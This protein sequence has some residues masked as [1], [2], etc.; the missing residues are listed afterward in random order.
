MSKFTKRNEKQVYIM[1]LHESP[2]PDVRIPFVN[3][4]F[5]PK[6]NCFLVVCTK[7][8]I[9]VKNL[10]RHFFN[11]TWSY[12]EKSDIYDPYGYKIVQKSTELEEQYWKS[13]NLPIQDMEE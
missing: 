12:K 5:I 13:H 2:R 6:Y 4:K 11:W 3:R 9:I 1:R 10:F 8:C 7:F